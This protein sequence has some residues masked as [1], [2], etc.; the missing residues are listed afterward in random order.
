MDILTQVSFVV[1]ASATVFAVFIHFYTK[2]H[3]LED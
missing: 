2:K 3:P 1:A